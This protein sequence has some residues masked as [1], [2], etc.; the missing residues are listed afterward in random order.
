MA[1]KIVTQSDDRSSADP[2]DELIASGISARTLIAHPLVCVEWLAAHRG[3]TFKLCYFGEGGQERGE[4]IVETVKGAKDLLRRAKELRWSPLKSELSED[5]G[6]F[7]FEEPVYHKRRGVHWYA[8]AIA[9]DTLAGLPLGFPAKTLEAAR[10][11]YET[12]FGDEAVEKRKREWD[13]RYAKER[14]AEHHEEI[15]GAIRLLTENALFAAEL[16]GKPISRRTA[17]KR[18]REK[19]KACTDAEYLVWLARGAKIGAQVAAQGGE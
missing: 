16:T 10:R 9:S 11:H 7:L 15:E 5:G 12:Y 19:L 2:I 17:R 8:E 6:Q 13:A 18:A 14:D 3:D 1:T 4:V